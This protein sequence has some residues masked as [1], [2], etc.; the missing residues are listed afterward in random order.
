MRILY[1]RA[2]SIALLAI[3]LPT[4]ITAPVPRSLMTLVTLRAFAIELL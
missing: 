1:T 2:P 3:D 4:I